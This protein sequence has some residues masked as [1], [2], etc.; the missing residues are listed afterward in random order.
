MDVG[1][2]DHARERAHDVAIEPCDAIRRAG[3]H[4][5]RDVRDAQHDTAEATLV[6]RVHVDPVAPRADR[7]DAIVGFAELEFCSLQRLAYPL[8][9]GGQ[10]EP[11]LA[12]PPGPAAQ[13]GGPAL[14]EMAL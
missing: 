8:E 1:G 2:V 3:T 13:R 4:V 14:C 12:D 7:L 11:A 5:E 9:A 6:R 10:G